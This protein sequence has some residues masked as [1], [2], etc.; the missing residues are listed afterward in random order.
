MKSL[1]MIPIFFGCIILIKTSFYSKLRFCF[2]KMKYD[3]KKNLSYNFDFYKNF[4]YHIYKHEIVSNNS[5]FFFKKKCYFDHIT[6]N[7]IENLMRLNKLV[8]YRIFDGRIEIITKYH[9][10][11][12][13]DSTIENALKIAKKIKKLHDKNIVHNDLHE[14]NIIFDGKKFHI[15]DF[16][17]STNSRNIFQMFMS[18]NKK[19]SP[20]EDLIFSMNHKKRR[21]LRIWCIYIE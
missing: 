14:G 4:Y 11:A 3:K 7:E 20:I 16:G 8:D 13:Y 2:S 6:F 18:V 15:I 5:N 21:Y 19:I 17:S 10:Y 1:K 12:Y 9:E